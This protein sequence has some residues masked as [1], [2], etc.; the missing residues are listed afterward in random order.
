M[1][2]PA[3]LVE[4]ERSGL[5]ESVHLGHVV[6][7]DAGGD[8]VLAAGDPDGI[9][10]PR[11]SVKPLQAAAMLAAGLALQGSD[12]A[13]A[14]ASHSGEPFHLRGVEDMLTAA[15][16][17]A[18]AL[19][20]PP[21]LPYGEQARN[22]YLAAGRGPSRVAMNCS[23][24]HAAMLA[25]CQARGWPLATYL[26]P[27]HPLQQAIRATIEHCAGSAAVT[28]SVDGCGAPL[29]AVPLVGLARAFATLPELSPQVV[30]A[31]RDYPEYTGGTTRDITHLM[32]GVPG[33]VAKDGAEGVQAMVLDH[34]GRRFGAALKI[35]DGA[36]RARPVVAAAVLH[37]LGVRAAILDEHLHTP[38]LGGGRPAGEVRVASGWLA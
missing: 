28:A 23:G 20:C 25:T 21:D 22:T 4:V 5:V 37:A 26:D 1:T 9:V 32:R 17:D 35:A 24:K 18:Q 31:V 29:W 10:Y 11:S 3:V 13:L 19:Q 12:L 14:C 36:Q 33:L 16:L 34:D 6:V 7:V 30:T 38:V 27:G 8:V 15:G 2:P